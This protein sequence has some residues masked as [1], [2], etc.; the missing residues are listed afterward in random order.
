MKVRFKISKTLTAI[1]EME[2]VGLVE[3]LEQAFRAEINREERMLYT[4]FDF[5][6]SWKGYQDAIQYITKVCRNKPFLTIL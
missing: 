4:I 1:E 2:M 5:T 6:T 3:R